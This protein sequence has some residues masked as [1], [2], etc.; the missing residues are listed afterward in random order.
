MRG[1][2]LILA[3]GA[4]LFRYH[5]YEP[6]VYLPDGAALIAVTSDPQEA[7]SAPVGDAIVGNIHATLEALAKNVRQ[8]DRPLP[9]PQARPERAQISQA[10]LLPEAVFD[11]IAAT[12]PS[13]AI[14]LN[15]STS[16]TDFL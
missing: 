14:Y 13:N 4:Q 16:T 12:A 3:I 11:V 15:E 5:Q 10:P 8:S 2:A 1:P 7:A 6:G 9:T